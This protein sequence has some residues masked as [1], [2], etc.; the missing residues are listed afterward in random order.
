MP[1][2]RWRSEGE[3]PS[4][5]ASVVSGGDLEPC[6]ARVLTAEE[7]W[8]RT[9]PPSRFPGTDGGCPEPQ[10]VSVPLL[11]PDSV[12]TH[13][14]HC[15]ISTRYPLGVGSVEPGPHDGGP[16]AN[17]VHAPA[18]LDSKLP[19]TSAQAPEVQVSE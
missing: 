6:P 3:L 12:M 2:R 9:D 5:R 8:G 15:G 13:Y 11:G 14:P 17:S 19:A 4:P 7:E 18:A 1:Q 16:A 10:A